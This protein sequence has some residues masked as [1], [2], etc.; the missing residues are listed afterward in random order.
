MAADRPSGPMGTAPGGQWH[1]ARCEMRPEPFSLR[2]SHGRRQL[3][4]RAELRCVLE[5]AGIQ[6]AKRSPVLQREFRARDANVGLLLRPQVQED[7][8]RR[9]PSGNRRR[10]PALSGGHNCEFRGPKAAIA[11]VRDKWSHDYG[12]ES[13]SSTPL[14]S[15]IINSGSSAFDP[16]RPHAVKNASRSEELDSS[17][18]GNPDA[19]GTRIDAAATIGAREIFAGFTP[20]LGPAL[21]M[22][23]PWT[24]GV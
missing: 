19:G 13:M 1:H 20:A 12:E 7:C 6:S 18:A 10:G 8:L 16:G 22:A 11:P 17:V 15:L 4:S 5:S 2:P 23:A 3:P 9:E 21:T 14:V 24:A